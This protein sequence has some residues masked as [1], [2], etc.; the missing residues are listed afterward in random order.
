[1]GG[2]GP[3]G[4]LHFRDMLV[5]ALCLKNTVGTEIESLL[6]RVEDEVESG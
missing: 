2:Q 6:D 3:K 4:L 5:Y 1:M